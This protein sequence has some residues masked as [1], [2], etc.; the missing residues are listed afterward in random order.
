LKLGLFT[1]EWCDLIF[2]GRNKSFGAYELRKSYDKRLGIAMGLVIGGAAL[3]FVAP[4]L[5]FFSGERSS[6]ASIE[7][8]NLS[9]IEM[10][11]DPIPDMPKDPVQE[12]DLAG[13]SPE[14]EKP[15]PEPPKLEGS[16]KIEPDG[17]AEKLNAG[18]LE[19]NGTEEFPPSL[20]KQDK[21]QVKEEDSE[22][23]PALPSSSIVDEMPLFNGGEAVSAFREFVAKN[24][25]YPEAEMDAKVGGIVYVQF[26]VEK[27]GSLSHV[28]ILKGVSPKIDEA[29][30]AVISKSPAWLPGKQKGKPVRVAYTFPIE[31]QPD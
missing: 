27:D 15:K 24:L 18:N 2:K 14:E 5:I 7:V 21:M 31:F 28:K 10:E 13:S 11:Q 29:V 23:E 6:V 4:Q 1:R 30:L 25:R 3:F 20:G 12:Q 22:S 8:T 16:I 19:G 17:K 26:V 9:K